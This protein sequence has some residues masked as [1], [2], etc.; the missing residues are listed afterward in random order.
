MQHQQQ[1]PS[2]VLDRV[3]FSFE[4]GT[5]VFQDLS[6][7][8]RAGVTGIIGP[9]GLGKSVLLR[10]V[11]GE[12][13]PTSGHV[14]RP[15]HVAVLPQG[16]TLQSHRTLA[17]LLGV[18]STRLAIT[19]LT[20]RDPS[21]ERA[22]ELLEKI[23]ERW[24]AEEEALAALDSVG[25]GSVA[26][27]D[28]GLMRTVE[29]LSGGEAMLLALAGLR[30]GAPELTL[31]DEPSNNLDDAARE[32]L[33]DALRGWPGSVL[34]VSHDRSLLRGAEAIAE[35]RPRRVRAGR[36]EGVI[37]EQFGGGWEDYSARRAAAQAAASREVRDA[38]STLA[39]ERRTR[40]GAETALARSARQGKE[41]AKSMPK[42]L[43]NTRKN[44]AEGTAGR[45]RTA[46]AARVGDAELALEEAKE[47]VREVASI[48]IDLPGTALNNAVVALSARVPR[49]PG[50]VLM[51][52]GVWLG[53]GAPL[54]LR[55]PEVVAL[56]GPNGS[57]KSTLLEAILPDAVVPTGVL[58]QRTG[59]GVQTGSGTEE[60]SEEVLGT[61]DLF[62]DQDSVLSNLLRVVP[63]LVEARAREVLARLRLR[64]DRVMEPLGHLSGGE[65][66]RVDLARVLAA[67][68][69][70]RLLVL[71]EPT[72]D[73]DLESVQALA[74]ALRHYA[75]AV[76]V[77][78]HDADFRASLG[79]TRRWELAPAT[80]Q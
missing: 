15:G 40:Q 28:A 47:A 1:H 11:S 42:I 46:H 38:E 48:D 73:L 74:Q 39:K 26:D 59:A 6:T 61:Q 31:L 76:V 58:R 14:S 52:D 70:P 35:L 23:G 50:T 43:A 64:G 24:N 63:E 17:D 54:Q 78:S 5:E 66:F 25:L 62:R 34:V 51:D 21:P 49:L 60:G 18:Q 67:D 37:L 4:D 3:S 7:T 27:S 2:V 29:T 53:Q 22:A 71:D 10:L 65:R 68:P 80:A 41:A 56:T 9:N 44:A 55:G 36:A 20:E 79:V 57:G 72:N 19:E 75:G 16:L 32:R 30:R 12:L 45:V 77:V 69:P 13:S 8:F 33:S